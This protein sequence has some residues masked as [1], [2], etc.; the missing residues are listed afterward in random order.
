LDIP[1]TNTNRLIHSTNATTG[2]E[3]RF[4]RLIVQPQ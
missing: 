2:G 4:Y 1:P 3:S